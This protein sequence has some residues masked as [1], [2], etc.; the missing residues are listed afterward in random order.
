MKKE[1]LNVLDLKH[2][3]KHSFMWIILGMG[4]LGCFMSNSLSGHNLSAGNELCRFETDN[5]AKTDT[6]VDGSDGVWVFVGDKWIWISPNEP[7][8]EDFPGLY[9]PMPLDES[10]DDE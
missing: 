6:V 9:D 5:Y 2:A 4:S 7:I 8:N 10:M 3:V 1:I